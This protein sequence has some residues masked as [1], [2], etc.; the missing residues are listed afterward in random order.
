MG[1]TASSEHHEFAETVVRPVA[2]EHDRKQEFP[3][4]VV[5]EAAHQGFYNPLFYRDII[6]DPT[7][8]L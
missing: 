6:G 1:L 5:E 2:A 8:L 4:P 7:G 3:C